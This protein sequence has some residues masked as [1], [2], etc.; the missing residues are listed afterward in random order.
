MESSRLVF[1]IVFCVSLYLL[2]EKWI[3]QH[4]PKN[5]KPVATN[6]SR[7]IAPPASPAT[8]LRG[9]AGTQAQTAASPT[10]SGAPVPSGDIVTVVTDVL[11]VDISTV[12]GDV[13]RV[14]FLKHRDSVKPDVNFVLL[15]S[16]SNHTY[17]GQ[18]GILGSQA[19]NHKTIFTTTS[20]SV[21]LDAG[22]DSVSV[23]LEGRSDSGAVLRKTYRFRRGDYVIVLANEL[24]GTLPA[25]TPSAYFQLV[26][27]DQAPGG[28]SRWVPTFNGIAVYTD[29]DK[30]QKVAFSDLEKGKASHAKSS[31]DG[32]IGMVQHYFVSAWLPPNGANRE[33]FT[34]SLG[35]NLYAAGVIVPMAATPDGKWSLEMLLYAGPQ[36]QDKLAALSK[37]LEL[38]VDYGW[39]T[40][41]ATP[42]FALL[43]AIHEWGVKNWGVAIII[44][45][46]LIKLLFFPL[47][48]A[49]Y[50]SMAKM[51]ILAPK[52]QKLKEQYGDDRQKMHQ[53][54]MELYKT[55]KINPLGGCLPIVIQIPVFISLY[56]VLLGSVEIR[57][58]PFML[59]IK[60]LSSPDP[61][62]ILPV[63]MGIS[64]IVQSRLN[65][66]PPDP[67]QA[68]VMKIMPVAFSVFFF[69]FP[70]GLVLYWLVNNI[71]SIAQQWF[72]TR[73]LEQAGLG[74][75]KR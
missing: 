60:D 4:E 8:E 38:T 51:R 40:I 25:G 31:T 65:P 14:E 19:P 39:L 26:R 13:R 29:K 9:Q 33:F 1:L 2:G 75:P 56:W 59:W 52:L 36:E 22:Q 73:Q 3:Q 64:M 70:A 54:M 32:W 18:S 11:K 74:A 63:L 72:I 43:S 17:I 28:E 5:E 37:G 6:Q 66:E 7:S 48:A 10:D 45:T 27:D 30:Y 35:G 47:S 16:T 20:R 71:L 53:A 55:E 42:L 68:K 67:I 61:L 15:D 34:K 24:S 21:A 44:V 49:S 23:V 69:F 62:Y 58:A 41:I 12:G 50:K 46:V 57:N